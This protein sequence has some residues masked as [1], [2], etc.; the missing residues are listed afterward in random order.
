[1]ILNQLNSVLNSI[2]FPRVCAAHPALSAG[3]SYGRIS[4]RSE[5]RL[6]WEKPRVRAQ[7][8][9]LS[10]LLLLRGFSR[11][12]TDRKGN[13]KHKEETP[14]DISHSSGLHNCVLLQQPFHCQNNLWYKP[15][16]KSNSQTYYAIKTVNYSIMELLKC[17]QQQEVQDKRP[18]TWSLPL[19]AVGVGR[20]TWRSSLMQT[21][22][23]WEGHTF[24]FLLMW[25]S[26]SSLTYRSL[27]VLF[28]ILG[29]W[30]WK[31]FCGIKHRSLLP[32]GH[33]LVYTNGIW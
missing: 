7:S 18:G 6:S 24:P 32:N 13:P 19:H 3:L 10:E 20:D 8:P 11:S 9:H 15:K 1:M 4:G 23:F 16:L 25:R 22:G 26:P 29:T 27:P 30:K 31:Q 12:Q 14:A 17:V 2:S 28:I 5:Q 33:L 21:V